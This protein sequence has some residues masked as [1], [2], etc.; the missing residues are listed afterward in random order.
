[1]G[2]FMIRKGYDKD[3]ALLREIKAAGLPV[4]LY[5]VGLI[6]DTAR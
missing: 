1:M 6:A 2:K 5:G 3:E 4:V